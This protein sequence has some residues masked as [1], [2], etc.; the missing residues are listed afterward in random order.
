MVLHIALG[1]AVAGVLLIFGSMALAGFDP[2]RRPTFVQSFLSGVGLI[3]FAAAMS[4]A[5]IHGIAVAGGW[6]V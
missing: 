4:L 5:T 1:L 3:L 6:S 2:Y